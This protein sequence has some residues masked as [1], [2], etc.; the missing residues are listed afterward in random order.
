MYCSTVGENCPIRTERSH[1]NDSAKIPA[2]RKVSASTSEKTSDVSEDKTVTSGFERK[3]I[4]HNEQELKETDKVQDDTKTV[5][6]ETQVP[7]VNRPNIETVSLKDEPA[8][9][10]EVM[11]DEDEIAGDNE[12]E[13][14]SYTRMKENF[15]D[16][17]DAIEKT[18]LFKEKCDKVDIKLFEKGVFHILAS[19]YDTRANEN[20]I[21]KG[22]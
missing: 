15:A 1:T 10:I 18:T 11:S 19:I 2:P 6:G 21:R 7:L 20:R 9:A 22:G 8:H 13:T 12:R 16:D 3:N 4:D 17:L 14:F 5:H